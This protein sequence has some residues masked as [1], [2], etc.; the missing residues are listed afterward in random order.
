MDGLNTDV[1]AKEEG[2]GSS[3]GA[4]EGSYGSSWYK[5]EYIASDNKSINIVHISYH[6]ITKK[7]YLQEHNLNRQN[8]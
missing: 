5:K 3:N 4:I 6:H 7:I 1:A 8:A 2:L